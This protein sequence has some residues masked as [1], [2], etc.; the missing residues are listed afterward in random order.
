MTDSEPPSQLWRSPWVRGIGVWFAYLGIA[1][2]A[3]WPLCWSPASTI[4]TGFEFVSTVPLLNVWTLWWNSDRAAAG[5]H[6]YWDAPIFYPTKGTFAF[7]EAQPTMLIAAPIVWLTGSR[8]LAYNVY[9]LLILTLNG[10][11][12]QRLLQRVGHHPWLAF[13]GGVMSQMLPFIWWQSGVVQLTTLFGIVWTIHAL[14][15][16]FDPKQTSGRGA[17][18][19]D[20]LSIGGVL[21]RSICNRS[22]RPTHFVQDWKEHVAR[23]V[24]WSGSA[25]RGLKLGTAFC[26][27]YLLCNYWGLFLVMI[28]VPSSIWLWNI[29]LFRFRFWGEIG[30]AAVLAFAVLAPLI[31]VQRSL[32]REHQWT[33]EQS[34]IRSLSSHPRDFLDTPRTTSQKEHF[35]KRISSSDHNEQPETP[36][37]EVWSLFPGM[38]APEDERRDLWPLGGGMLK[39]ILAPIGLLAALAMR[40]RRRWGL[41]AATFALVA[42]GLSLGLTV[43][44]ASWVPGLAG[45]CLYERLQQYVPGFSLIRSPFRFALFVQLAI[46]WLSVE[47][48]DLLNPGRWQRVRTA[49]IPEAP[50]ADIDP[51]MATTETG[52]AELRVV[53]SDA[54]TRPQSAKTLLIYWC[55]RCPL[56]LQSLILICEVWP[57]RQGMYICPSAAKVP[58]WILWLRE[59]S[60]PDDALICL[61]FPTGYTVHH[62]QETTVWMYWGTLH[63]RPLVNGY[64]GF[65]PERFMVFKD[66]LAVF[67][68]GDEQPLI[69]QLKMYPWDSPGLKE[70]N[71]CGARFAIVNRSFATRD[72][73][74]QHTATKFRWG[75]VTSDE[76]HELDIYEILPED[77]E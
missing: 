46:V 28:V 6:G 68:H 34:L 1:V 3:T 77:P 51:P 67:Y 17:T 10:W 57:P 70:L 50:L 61:P 59:N 27:T 36:E 75:W 64:S 69:P 32:A 2:F 38:D 73:V 37:T 42:F 72:D 21:T 31:H 74:W 23:D 53:L 24:D 60:K 9:L 33:R 14:L 41:F 5:F 44:I 66:Q 65:F 11:S 16:V 8:V 18:F 56:I 20:I 40:G 25:W 35:A 49:K 26:L 7:S 30:L 47:A 19:K 62:Y 43:R 13:C 12:S 63:G 76:Q 58:A 48:L 71:K 39:L 45:E 29:S 22:E 15:D 52:T 4:S 54:S 55:L